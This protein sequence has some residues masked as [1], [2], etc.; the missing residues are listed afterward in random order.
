MPTRARIR[1]SLMARL[2]NRLPGTLG[3]LLGAAVLLL[4]L[5][6]NGN[7]K[8]Q[9]A[10]PVLT[11]FTAARQVISAGQS[12][13]LTVVYRNGQAGIYALPADAAPGTPRSYL[14][15][16]AGSG[17]SLPVT[18]AATTVYTAELTVV[19]GGVRKTVVSEPLTVKVA[20]LPTT[21]VI[22]VNAA[23]VGPDQTY[24]ASVPE[25]EDSTYLWS[26]A[27]RGGGEITDGAT[28]PTVTFHTA[29][30]G[31]LILRCT[32]ANAAGDEATGES[33]PLFLGG[34]TVVSFTART[35]ADQLGEQLFVTD[36]VPINLDF[37]ISGGTGSI[38]MASDGGAPV[39]VADGLSQF[40]TTLLVTPPADAATV[41]TLVVADPAANPPR[42]STQKLTVTAVPTPAI[43]RFGAL[44]S[45]AILGPGQ[46]ADLLARFSAGPGARAEVDHD[47][48]ALEDGQPAGGGTLERT[49]TFTL[50]VT[51]AEG[52]A[53]PSA[54]AERVTATATATVLV[55]SLA[56]F[57]GA[58]SGQGS[59]DLGRGQQVAPAAAAVDAQG[60]V[61]VADPDLQVIRGITPNG[62]V[63][64]VAGLEGVPGSADGLGAAARF[65]RPAGLALDPA[66]GLLYVADA[67]NHVIRRVTITPQGGQVALFAGTPG[68]PGASD[69]TQ[70]GS[71]AGA[72]FW[73]PQGLVWGNGVLYVA[74]TGNATIRTIQADGTVAT[75]CGVAGVT[76]NQGGAA[77]HNLPVGAD[78]AG[79][80]LFDQPAGV[81][82]YDGSVYVADTGNNR[83]RVI[84]AAGVADPVPALALNP[85]GTPGSAD[86]APNAAQFDHPR[87]VAAGTDG[88]LIVADTGNDAIRVVNLFGSNQVATLA[89][90]SGDPGAADGVA[91]RFDQPQGVAVNADNTLVVVADTG[92]SLVRALPAGANPNVQTLAGAPPI[93]GDADGPALDARMRRPRG[94]ALG[95]DGRLVL[96]DSGNHTLRVVRT[97]RTDPAH[98]VTTVATLAGAAGMPG[99]QDSAAGPPRFREPGAVAL[100]ADGTVYVADTGNHAVRRVAPDGTVTTV[101]GD[102]TPGADNSAGSGPDGARF[103]R[104]MGIALQ[105]DGGLVVADTGND[106]LRR[107][108]PDGTVTTLAGAAG[109]PGAADGQALAEAR[110]DGPEAVAVARDG[111]ILVADTRNHTVRAL[112]LASGQVATVA[113]QAGVGGTQDGTG[114][115][116]LLDLPA[117][118]AL[119]KDGNLFVANRGSSTLCTLDPEGGV[120][121]FLGDPAVS[122]NPASLRDLAGTGTAPLPAQLAP[123]RG[124]AVDADPDHP[125]TPVPLCRRRRRRAGGGLQTLALTESARVG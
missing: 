61:Y 104:P 3:G 14:G 62:E 109:T 68:Q 15:P 80:A 72:A 33:Q 92:N 59:A 91:A 125:F 9:F 6:C 10:D 35:D 12:T 85:A 40:Q 99:F 41:Y 95:A 74:D 48:G 98:P 88:R 97:D 105:P 100:A 31:K 87:G 55:G 65:D 89:G 29:P 96:A 93:R 26:V 107:I 51:N 124:L 39:P 110:F 115:D 121:H 16:V 38:T 82:W 58:A 28:A 21:P 34:P 20:A 11:S 66:T 111:R 5:R 108:A 86:G 75:F 112:D 70:P 73:N 117:A 30:F 79:Y 2:L 46:A 13:S 43:A 102:G 57:A 123:P 8:P 94:A 1:S 47:V 77:A 56:R 84:T 81:A 64:T 69:S 18:P 17:I 52:L 114:T 42:V 120:H 101:A 113:G 23:S 37:A 103:N 24:T 90:V 63:W 25:Q 44:P 71:T 106:T 119:D 50:T 36:G 118:L 32:V 53:D 78:P 45:P 7:D 122:G 54:P 49:T 67:G 27:N 4:A 19:V 116:A 60:N 76:G 83:I 22:T